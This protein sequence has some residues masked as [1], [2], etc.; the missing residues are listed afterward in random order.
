MSV[1]LRMCEVGSELQQPRG[2]GLLRDFL[3]LPSYVFRDDPNWVRPLDFELTE[4]LSKKNPFFQH[5]EGVVLVAYRNG[6]PVGRCTAQV[7]HEHLARHKD[8]TGF[9]GFFD[10]VDE[11]EVASAL[12]EKAGGWLKERG[13]RAVRGPMSLS[14]NEEM[15]CLVNG[16]DTR[17][18]IMMP[19]HR[20]YQGGLIEAA[21]Y[22]K[23]KDVYAWYY[24]PGAISERARRASEEI[25]KLPEVTSRPLDLS[26]LER[27]I[28]VGMDI[29]NDAWSDNWGFVPLT[30]AELKKMASDLR[31]LL[32]KEMTMIVSIDGEPAGICIALPDLNSMIYDFDGKLSPLNVARLLWRLKGLKPHRAR[33]VLL[34]IRKKWRHVRK[35]AAL[36]AFMYAQINEAGRKIHIREAELSWTLEDNGPVNTGIKVVGGKI[37]KTYRVYQHEL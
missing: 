11:P 30:E 13:M 15:G 10:T 1:E 33:L 24:T 27:D 3:D 31:L 26:N 5:A 35:Y 19:H 18:M 32:I 6:R 4:R 29:F 23:I 20:P 36:S 16:F 9:F 21:G 7:D 12:L 28:R 14:I 37:Y 2:K 17:P 25:K 34:G 22:R 8:A